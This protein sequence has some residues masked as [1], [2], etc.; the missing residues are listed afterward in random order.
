[1]TVELI[2]RM[3]DACYLAKRARD[4]LP[5]LPDGVQ[6]SYIQFLD[7][8]Q[9]LQA[10][11]MQVRVSDLSDALDLPR[12][13]VTRTVKE[14]EA[15]GY[16]T[17]QVSA[18]DGRVTYLSLTEAGKALSRE[19]D[20]DYFRELASYRAGIPEADAECTIRTLEAF[21]AIMCERRNS[22]EKRSI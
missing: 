21:H 19:Y 20:A 14:M 15:K 2:K 12:P 6:P 10:K 5:P 22:L 17:K 16:L 9:K 18:Q 1:M 11:E 13:G 3:M 4:M 8:I 7:A